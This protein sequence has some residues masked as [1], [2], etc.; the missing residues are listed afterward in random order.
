[1]KKGLGRG[2]SSLIPDDLLDESFD[3]SAGDDHKVSDLRNI[4][5]SDIS[6]DPDQPRRHF[7]ETGL[8]ELSASI[9]E[10]GVLQPIVVVPLKEGKY[11]IVAGERRYRAS[12]AAGKGSIPALVRTLS[13]QHKLELSLIENI[14]RRDLNPLETATA[15]VKLRDQFNLTL[16]EIGT[17]VGGK[18]VSAIS[19]TLRLLKLPADA[20][21]AVAEGKLTEG[22]ARPLIGIEE[23]LVNQVLP[24]IINEHWS[25]RRVEEYVAT[26]RPVKATE[27]KVQKPRR[28]VELPVLMKRFGTR[29]TTQ[30]NNRGVGKIVIEFTSEEE[31][32]R[33]EAQ[34]GQ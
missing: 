27:G 21:Q 29:V 11:Q 28:L 18:S 8:A 4:K 5:L 12:V 25:A 24:K 6:P 16:E 22:Q 34:L 33:I 19:N 15:Y 3:P 7:D 14:Q 26:A 13:A 1:M 17:R 31:R 20:K 10:H 2:F 9:A 30:Q 32:Q 23:S